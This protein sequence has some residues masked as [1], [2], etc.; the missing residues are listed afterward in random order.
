MQLNNRLFVT[1]SNFTVTD[2]QLKNVVI[3]S[4]SE[5]LRISYW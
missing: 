3:E 1:C 4:V 2:L 5:K